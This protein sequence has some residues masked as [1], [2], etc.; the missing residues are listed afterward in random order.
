[1]RL[2][3]S[4]QHTLPRRPS[5]SGSPLQVAPPSAPT[6]QLQPAPS[7]PCL[8]TPAPSPVEYS[9]PPHSHPPQHPRKHPP[10]HQNRYN[11]PDTHTQPPP[12][13]IAKTIT[14]LDLNKDP[15]STKANTQL[16]WLPMTEITPRCLHRSITPAESGPARASASH[17]YTH[18]H[19]Q[20]HRCHAHTRTV[21]HSAQRHTHTR[22]HAHTHTRT[23]ARTHARP[24]THTHP[25][26]PT[27][28]KPQPRLALSYLNNSQPPTRLHIALP[29]VSHHTT[30]LFSPSTI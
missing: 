3:L 6:C 10:P 1:M 27:L 25:H 26:T 30:Y 20:C 4:H 12:R 15:P 9:P 19:T 2:H 8:A 7:G 18:A 5:Y 21:P 16:S 23:H 17:A 13:Q 28:L 24:H 22:T 14:N 29:S 11:K